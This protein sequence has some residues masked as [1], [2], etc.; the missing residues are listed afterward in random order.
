MDKRINYRAKE[1]V[2]AYFLNK[3]RES[4]MNQENERRRALKEQRSDS[5]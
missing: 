3:H 5:K 2:L 1:E 4:L